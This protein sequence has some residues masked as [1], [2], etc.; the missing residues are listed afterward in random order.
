M[1]DRTDEERRSRF[2]R[3]VFQS[4]LLLS[5][6]V[7]LL[8][9]AAY[10]FQ[11]AS[12]LDPR[13]FGGVSVIFV[14][15]GASAL[16][17]WSRLDRHWAALLPVID[18]FAII[19]LREG[20]NLLGAGLL[21]TFPVIWLSTHFGLVGAVGG[22]ITSAVLLWGSAL[23]NGTGVTLA[24]VPALLV[25]PITLAFIATTTL[26]TS[27]RTAAQRGLLRQQADLLEVALR[28]AR[29]QEQTLDEVLNAV[30]FGV[31]AFG[32]DGAQTLLN[33]AHRGFQA[34]FGLPETT[35]EPPVMYHADR[36]TPY[37]D[38]ERPYG[39]AVRG[40]RFDD[41]VVWLGEPGEHRIALSV[42][43]RQL[44]APD[45]APDGGVM[46]SRDVTREINAI[47][48]RDDLVASVSHELRTPLTSILG[49]LELAL[50][51]ETLNPSTRS[52]LEVASANSDRLLALV[53]DL[54]TAASEKDQQIVMSFSSCDLAEIVADSI[55]AQS[56]AA[57]E[58]GISLK[59]AVEGPM[60]L[61]AD[62]F[63]LRQVVDNLLTNAIKYN[64][65][66]GSVAV[67]ATAGD[68]SIDL[69]V[70]DTGIGLSEL[71]QSKL[72]D[73]YFRAEGV[74]QSSIHGSGLGLS[75]S[76]DIVRRHGGELSVASAVGVGTT[77]TAT[78]PRAR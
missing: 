62:G 16:V 70:S 34:E 29:R 76:R 10:I 42:S 58:R 9:C 33:R 45:G 77:F 4:Q 41:V 15:T 61:E 26:A 30:T 54:L 50:D 68:D 66:N 72:F 60:L 40:E 12:V 32:R 57:G 27:S 69:V 49:Y 39:R 71:E 1:T 3:S 24:G 56:L 28:R 53:A 52:M 65:E 22:V 5:A 20:N 73:R 13:F 38:E 36:V 51:D 35:I 11:P 47:Q 55:Q 44:T 19:F 6:A 25:L 67:S 78:I 7:L 75:I 14:L 64:V 23:V 74:R 43:S 17:P 59:N 48:A 18:I 31:V 46:V 63:R 37:L 2:E 8:V 21:L